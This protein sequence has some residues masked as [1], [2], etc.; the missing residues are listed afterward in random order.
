LPSSTLIAF[1][2]LTSNAFADALLLAGE[3]QHLRGFVQKAGQRDPHLR[4]VE[5]AAALAEQGN[6]RGRAAL[7]RRAHAEC[8]VALGD[9]GSMG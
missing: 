5:K 7:Q 4:V 6:R 1:T 3:L 2:A 8:R 9:A